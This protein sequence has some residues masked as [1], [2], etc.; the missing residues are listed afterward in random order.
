MAF[1][2]A[3]GT[4]I[5]ENVK[6]CTACGNPAGDS[7]PAAPAQQPMPAQQ[8]PSEPYQPQLE[9]HSQPMPRPEPQQAMPQQQ[10]AYVPPQP[11]PQPVYAPPVAP[12]PPVSQGQYAAPAAAPA[13]AAPPDKR[14]PYGVM[15]VMSY[16]GF[17]ILYALP[18]IGWLFCL[19][20]AFALKNRN[21]RNYARAT[22]IFMLV[23]LV[24]AVL[25]YIALGW[26]AEVIVEYYGGVSGAGT[27]GA[28]KSLFD[29]IP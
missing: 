20:M 1:C 5:P 9:L 16:I 10:G 25:V 11:Q 14:G 23:G 29:I 3:C 12:A 6:F 13:A 2:T 4:D 18:L 7:A 21:K 24:I 27:L 19:I 22:L 8:K 28:L 26:V 17:G 15:G